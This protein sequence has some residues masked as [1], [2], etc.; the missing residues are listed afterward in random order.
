MTG[1]RGRG[2]GTPSA[3]LLTLAA[4][5]AAGVLSLAAVPASAPAA[6]AAAVLPVCAAASLAPVYVDSTGAAGSVD[7]EFGFANRGARRC[8]L[9]GFPTVA[10]RT[11]SGAP[12]STSEHH[13]PGAYGIPLAQV[14][15]AHG[16]VAY[17]GVHYAAQ[18]GYGTLRCP[19]SAEVEITAPGTTRGL[20]VRGA[21]GRIQAYGGSTVHLHCGILDV[22]P[23]GAKRFQ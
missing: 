1:D 22:S 9:G 4:A 10:L 2:V 16:A 6:S 5:L 8:E 21:G 17:F 20:V 18:T 19:T 23:L 14:P 11:R 3:V 13:V 7:A 15:L 12:L